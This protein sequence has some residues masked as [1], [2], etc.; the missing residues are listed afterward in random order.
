M[1]KENFL[2]VSNLEVIFSR[3]ALAIQGVSVH[4]AKGEITALI[5]VNGAGKTTIVRAICGFLSS[6][7]VEISDGY[8]KFEGERVDGMPP[9]QIAKR[10]IIVVPEREKVFETLTVEENLCTSVFQGGASEQR[11]VLQQVYEYF[12]ALK[13]LRRQDAGYLSGGE[14][15]MVAIGAA[16][17]C[18]PKLLVLDELSLGLAP[19]VVNELMAILKRLREDLGMSILSVEQNAKA[20]LDIADYGYVVENGHVVFDGTPDKLLSSDDLKEF[21]L[22][23]RKDGE[24]QDYRAVKQYRRVRRWWG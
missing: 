12:P 20:I 18:S 6:E 5:G 16:L 15:Q 24:V 2:R 9:H 4:M 7:D 8:I 23:I 11:Q 19:I 21:Y 10:G 1:S 17:M 22:G 13:R 3:S 14:R